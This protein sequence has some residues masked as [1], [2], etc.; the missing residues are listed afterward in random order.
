M[1]PFVPP[2]MREFGAGKSRRIASLLQIEL[3]VIDAAKNVRYQNH[4]HV[5]RLGRPNEGA[6]KAQKRQS[7]K[8]DITTCTQT[9]MTQ[10]GILGFLARMTQSN[11]AFCQAADRARLNCRDFRFGRKS[12]HSPT[13]VGMWVQLPG[14]RSE[15]PAD[16]ASGAV[17]SGLLV[18]LEPYRG[19][20]ARIEN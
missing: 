8:D 4:G 9:R 6:A 19:P 20:A 17:L 15:L 16:V 13:E 18:R 5:D 1:A 10:R 12:R 11:T 3:A 2:G 14:R 7:G